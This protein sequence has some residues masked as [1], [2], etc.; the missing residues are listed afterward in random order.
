MYIERCFGSLDKARALNP[1]NPRIYF[2]EAMNRLNLPPAFGGGPEVALPL[3]QT[4]QEKFSLFHTEDPLWPDWGAD[5]NREE[6]AK[7]TAE[8]S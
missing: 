3:F 6:L 7:L 1:D 2:L 4:A 8:G 5:A